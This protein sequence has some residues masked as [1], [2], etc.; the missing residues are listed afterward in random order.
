M[1]TGGKGDALA[2]A[3]KSAMGAR[4][5]IALINYGLFWALTRLVDVPVLGGFSLLMNIFF[6]LQL[7]PLLGLAVPVMRRAATHPEALAD[8]IS[9]A[10]YFALPVA[11]AIALGVGAWGGY[12]HAADLAPSFWLIGLSLVPTAWTIVAEAVLVGQEKFGDI[13]RV[14]FIECLLRS[15]LALVAIG[16]GGGLTGVFVAMLLMRFVAAALY[17]RHPGLSLPRWQRVTRA[18]Q[19]RNW[20]DVPVFLGIAI[21]TALVTRLDVIVL[22]SLRDLNEVAVYAAASRLYE[23]SLMVPTVMALVLMPVLARHFTVSRERFGP[24]LDV[25]VRTT[26]VA[27]LALALPASALSGWVIGVLYPPEM[28]GAAPVLGWLAFASAL[29]ITDVV[30]SST[31]I[32]ANAQKMDLRCLAVGLAG[33]VAGLCVCIPLWGATGAALA[34]V[35]G[36]LART[37]WRLRW[38]RREFALPPTGFLLARL[39]LAGGCGIAALRWAAVHGAVAAAAASF[40]AF[41]FAAVLLGVWGRHPLARL[42]A[43]VALLARH[44]PAVAVPDVPPGARSVR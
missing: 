15:V 1:K 18:L 41:G 40:V 26:L 30:L 9:N 29:M 11:L 32:A 21:V 19:R 10:F 28:A 39:A 6:L 17:A 3:F 12:S 8:E 4:L 13:T 23:A 42:R 25:V 7:L 38:S 16:L 34:V 5:A 33:L 35:A 22:S 20:Q 27:G 37:V 43:D 44:E 31:M 2:R 24:T 36:L 14:V